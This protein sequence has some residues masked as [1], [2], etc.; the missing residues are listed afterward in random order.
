MGFSLS[1]QI[2]AKEF[3]PLSTVSIFSFDSENDLF[4]AIYFANDVKAD[5]RFRNKKGKKLR[6]LINCRSQVVK[7]SVLYLC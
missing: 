4:V 2:S 7:S 6:K 5:I 3:I 1:S